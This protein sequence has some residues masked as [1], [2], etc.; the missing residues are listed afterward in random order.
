MK[1]YRNVDSDKNNNQQINQLCFIF[2]AL[3]LASCST[4]SP[5]SQT[6]YRN[7]GSQVP[8]LGLKY[9]APEPKCSTSTPKGLFERVINIPQVHHKCS[10][11]AKKEISEIT[12]QLQ[13]TEYCAITDETG[14]RL[15][16]AT[17]RNRLAETVVRINMSNW[18]TLADGALEIGCLKEADDIYR[19]ILNFKVG[20]LP[21]RDAADAK[22]RAKVGVEDVREKTRN[23][24][25]AKL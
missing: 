11:D 5:T 17:G 6:Q 25:Q 3:T 1:A 20:Y 12:S 24:K 19:S 7:A 8:D 10:A 18:F 23:S 13:S 14:V 4:T 16:S 22:D 21:E 2:L 9:E 15:M